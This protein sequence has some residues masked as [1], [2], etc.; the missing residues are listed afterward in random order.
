MRMEQSESESHM[1]YIWQYTATNE[2]KEIEEGKIII[3]LLIAV[4]VWKYTT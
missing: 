2:W 1:L 4:L 3:C